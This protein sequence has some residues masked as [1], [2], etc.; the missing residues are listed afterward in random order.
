MNY[1]LILLLI[2]LPVFSATQITINQHSP[3]ASRAEK[4]D[5]VRNLS[6]N[7]AFEEK[8]RVVLPNGKVLIKHQQLYKG[9]PVM[10]GYIITQDKE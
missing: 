8:T 6:E 9:I 5:T 2:S 7:Y 10:D 1:I 3:E 4:I